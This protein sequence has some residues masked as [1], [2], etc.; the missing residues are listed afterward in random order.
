MIQGR[1][2]PTSSQVSGVQVT[3][4][5]ENTPRKTATNLTP[6]PARKRAPSNSFEVLN[7]FPVGV[8]EAAEN[9]SEASSTSVHFKRKKAK[10]NVVPG[11]R[12]VT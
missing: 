5:P 7:C 6:W 12:P 11:H 2:T 9:S 10:Q 3:K 8:T 1:N 4:N